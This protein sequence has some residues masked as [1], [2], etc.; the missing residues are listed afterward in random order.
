MKIDTEDFRVRPG[1]KVDLGKLPTTVK[2][3]YKSKKPFSSA[4]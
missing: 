2:P 1:E 3:V 4:K